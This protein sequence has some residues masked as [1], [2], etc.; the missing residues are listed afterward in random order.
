MA[1][2]FKYEILK[3]GIDENS[4]VRYSSVISSKKFRAEY[5]DMITESI[6]NAMVLNYKNSL[7]KN[8]V[9]KKCKFVVP[10]FVGDG[11]KKIAKD[12]AKAVVDRLFG[13]G[14]WKE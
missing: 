14:E 5:E 9:F 7:M 12:N 4:K 2:N 6:Y 10:D 8:E 13:E 1:D 11:F 3:C